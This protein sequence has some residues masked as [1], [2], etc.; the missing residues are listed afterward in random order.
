MG[1]PPLNRRSVTVP[2]DPARGFRFETGWTLAARDRTDITYPALTF[3][4]EDHGTH[5]R[6]DGPDGRS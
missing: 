4:E 3:Q 6:E 5:S 1:E 2:P